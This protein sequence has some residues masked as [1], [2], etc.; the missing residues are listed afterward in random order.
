MNPYEV[1]GISKTASSGEIKKAYHKKAIKH[2][3]D[4]GGDG[5]KFKEISK[6]Y[7][8]L[9]DPK[10]KEKY[11]RFGVID[12]NGNPGGG[13][14]P[15]EIFA[16]LFG[17][18]GRGGPFNMNF[19]NGGS[20]SFG[21][22]R[23]QPGSKVNINGRMYHVDEN[24][25]PVEKANNIVE[26]IELSLL[27]IYNGKQVIIQDKYKV[28]IEPGSNYGKTFTF[29]GKGE[30]GVGN[31]QDGDLI[32]QLV[33]Q[34][35]DRMLRKY[36]IDNRGNLIYRKEINIIE[37]LT[38]LEYEIEHPDGNTYL[39]E[40]KEV[41]AYNDNIRIINEKGLPRNKEKTVFSDLVIQYDIHYRGIGAG[42]LSRLRKI[43]QVQKKA[44]EEDTIVLHT[45]K[46]GE[47]RGEI[48][49]VNRVSKE[50]D[51]SPGDCNA[52]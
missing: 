13:I 35:E 48:P 37:S 16:N 24:G 52:Q 29:K 6:A 9:S 25:K 36:K 4:K 42:I 43:N 23:F 10:A 5:E 44:R 30:K 26:N 12:E 41:I 20:F 45:R 40:E 21:G 49:R 33:P 32:I 8:I 47:R 22:M 27:D 51:D 31:Q 2:H 38:G 34:K 7:T 18:M 46:Q 17:G 3:P 15:T 19:Q 28:S 11:D 1:L 50:K 39:I 14:D